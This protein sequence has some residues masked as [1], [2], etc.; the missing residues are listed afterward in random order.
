MPAKLCKCGCGHEVTQVYKRTD[1][2]NGQIAGQLWDYLRGH[3]GAKTRLQDVKWQIDSDTGCWVWIACK[4]DGYGV[5]KIGERVKSAHRVIYERIKG[6]IPKGL[7]LDHLCQN[8]ACVNPDHLEPVTTAE[9]NFRKFKT[10]P[11]VQS[12]F[13]R[14]VS[15]C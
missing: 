10:K 2:Y 14:F 11:I 1:R 15:A 8:R 5:V 3:A 9:N 12:D 7:S 4:R 6:L 13:W